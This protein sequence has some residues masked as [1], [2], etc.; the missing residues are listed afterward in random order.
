MDKIGRRTKAPSRWDLR[1][2]SFELS[3]QLGALE[4]NGL[5]RRF[6]VN[7]MG[8]T[9]SSWLAKLLN[10]H[11]DV[12]CYH[13]GVIT[14][15]FPATAYTNDDIITFIRW[16]AEHDMNGA[17]KAVGDVGSAWTGH[18]IA[19]PKRL[20]TTGILLRHPARVLNSRLKVFPKDQSFTEID[21]ACLQH[22]EQIWGI[23]ASQ[24]SQIDQAF[25]QDLGNL[26]AQIQAAAS[27]DVIMHLERMNSD[28]EY[29]GDALHRLTGVYYEP[30]LIEPLLNSPV[31]RRTGGDVSIR[32]ILSFFS[33]EQRFWYRRMLQD[34]IAAF[35]YDL[36]S[37]EFPESQRRLS[38]VREASPT[39][40]EDPDQELN[41]LKGMLANRDRQ[42][43]RLRSRVEELEGIWNAV[44]SSAGWRL[45]DW[46]RRA[47]RRL[48][49]AGSRSR[50]FYDSVLRLFRGSAVTVH[51]R[52]RNR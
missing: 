35:G 13:E 6:L 19:M 20:F 45:L 3:S 23:K 37:D 11:P 9:G 28:V 29:C 4:L 40:V 46:W 14:R 27:T 32:S 1:D 33:E 36:D 44:Q 7:R 12:F 52:S 31:N 51:D 24:Q 10:T 41:T 25:L 15:I 5:H 47:R 26:V 16:L 39:N 2:V 8:S 38:E 50:K 21:E 17:Y 30:T 48:L 49:P 43:A 18:I 22:V 42:I 34:S